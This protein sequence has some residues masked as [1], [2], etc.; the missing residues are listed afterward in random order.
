MGL[1]SNKKAKELTLEIVRLRKHL[2][3][4]SRIHARFEI[5]NTAAI[6]IIEELIN[7]GVVDLVSIMDHTPGQGQFKTNNDYIN[8]YGKKYM[9]NNDALSRTIEKKIEVRANRGEGNINRMIKMCTENSI[10]MA[11]HDDDS[12]VK[13]KYLKARGISISEFPVNLDAAKSAKKEGLYVMLGAPNIVR[14]HSHLDNL[15]GLDAIRKK[16]GSVICSDYMVTSIL[17]AVFKLA[18]L[19]LYNL[20]DAVNFASLNPAKAVKL[21]GHKGSI[22]TGK[23]ADIVIVN[24]TFEIPII[25]KVFIKGEKVYERSSN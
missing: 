3:A 22:E 10:P 13:I 11:S 9:K 5:T 17:H 20:S 2:S 16:C 7:M 15:S 23:D 4:D 24:N 14:G 19:K 6:P 1:R 8:Y 21:D 18:Q 25:E 12:E